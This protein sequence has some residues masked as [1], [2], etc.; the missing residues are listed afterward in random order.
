VV[1]CAA[2]SR[3]QVTLL[4]PTTTPNVIRSMREFAPDAYYVSDDV[5]MR[6]ELPRFELPASTQ[7]RRDPGEM[8]RI[9]PDRVAACV[10]TSGST[11]QPAPHF[12][13]WGGLMRDVAG[14]ARRLDIGPRH[15]ILGTVPRSTCTGS[16]PP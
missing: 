2:V 11:G 15:A 13:T 6:V 5:A 8:Q 3:G 12:K 14:E 9:P 16:N 4:P 7:G 1:L 10:F